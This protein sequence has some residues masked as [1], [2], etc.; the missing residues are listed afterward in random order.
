MA[1]RAIED[2]RSKVHAIKRYVKTRWRSFIDTVER[3]VEQADSLR[4]Y[5]QAEE[6]T[7]RENYIFFMLKYCDVETLAMLIK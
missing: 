3:I 6:D 1:T 5:F 2:P 7:H 4:E